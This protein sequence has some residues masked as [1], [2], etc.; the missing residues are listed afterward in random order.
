MQL[1]DWHKADIVAALHKANTSCRKLSLEHGLSENT[2]RHAL[3]RPYLKTEK[4][5]ANALGLEPKTIWP[6]RFND[7]GTRKDKR[8]DLVLKGVETK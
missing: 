4:I 7:D 3:H 6:S 2:V 1:L 8:K 5:I